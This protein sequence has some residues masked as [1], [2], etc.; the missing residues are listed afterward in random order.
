ML[1]RAE[2]LVPA[3]PAALAAHKDIRYLRARH[4]QSPCS[5][6]IILA[7]GLASFI[8]LHLAQVEVLEEVMAPIKAG[9]VVMGASLPAAMQVVAVAGREVAVDGCISSL[10]L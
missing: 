10:R 1:D 4:Y 5:L 6:G 9:L 7:P 8:H 3:M 2:V